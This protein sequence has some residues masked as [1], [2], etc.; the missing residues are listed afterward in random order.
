MGRAFA[1]L[2]GRTCGLTSEADITHYQLTPD[3]RAIV[4]GSDGIFEYTS[5]EEVASVV[6]KFYE[7]K[8]AKKAAESLA[9][10]AAVRWKQVPPPKKLLILYF[11][12][13]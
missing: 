6:M 9:N 7:K 12:E 8:E 4:L 3:D 11:W 5:N 1:D 13:F 10:R 2:E